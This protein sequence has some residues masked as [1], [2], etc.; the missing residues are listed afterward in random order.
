MK[1]MGKGSINYY[2]GGFLDKGSINCYFGGTI[3]LWQKKV[4]SKGTIYSL[5]VT[6]GRKKSEIH[7]L[8]FFF[9]FVSVLAT[10]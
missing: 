10:I 8:L 6:R 2:Y 3:E 4:S 1:A 5:S 7:L 9:V